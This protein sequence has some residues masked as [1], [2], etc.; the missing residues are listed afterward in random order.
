M[1]PSAGCAVLVHALIEQADAG[2]DRRLS[3]FLDARGFLCH[4]RAGPDL[5]RA[6][7]LHLRADPLHE[8]AHREH[9]AAVF[10]QERRRPRQVQRVVLERQ[11]PLEGANQ[12]R[13]PARSI[14]ERRLAPTG[15][16]R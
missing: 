16:S 7:A 12:R 3:R 6:G 9:Q 2:L 11:R 5:D 15:S 10:V 4:R 13:R 8:L 1:K 14:A